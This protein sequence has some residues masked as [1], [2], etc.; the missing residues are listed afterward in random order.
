[1][2]CTWAGTAGDVLAVAKDK[3]VFDVIEHRHRKP[4]AASAGT[5]TRT[6][7]REHQ[8][9]VARAWLGVDQAVAGARAE[10]MASSPALNTP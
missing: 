2:M 7:S 3:F 10:I 6:W 1:M 5:G 4:A 9:K 8:G